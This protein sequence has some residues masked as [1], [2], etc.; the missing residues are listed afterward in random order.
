MV[1]PIWPNV[2]ATFRLVNPRPRA[3]RPVGRPPGPHD[4]TLA[5]ILPIAMELLL[6]EG[7]GALTP[8]RLNKETGVARATIYR[9]WPEPM[10]LIEVLLEEAAAQAR[11]L[12]CS[13]DLGPDLHRAMAEVLGRLD[14]GSTRAL[15]GVCIDY[16]RR[17]PLVAEAAD[18]FVA[19]LVEPFHQAFTAAADADHRLEGPVDELVA[20]LA[21]PVV[22][23]QLVMGHQI[24]EVRGRV[25][26]DHFLAHHCN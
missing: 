18:G 10:A 20:E 19:S 23:E 14:R 26:V 13:G 4:D 12:E 8:T 15:L 1:T 21:G 9:N 17:S 3:T 7:G 6:Q 5:K 16:G 22:L 2:R 24:D 11:S 25:I